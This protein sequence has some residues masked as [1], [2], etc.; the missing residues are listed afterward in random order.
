MDVAP[1]HTWMY[2]L[3][4]LKGGSAPPMRPNGTSANQWPFAQVQK[5]S[6]EYYKD[7]AV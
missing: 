3:R 2:L 1:E 4:V 5:T 6:C 7:H